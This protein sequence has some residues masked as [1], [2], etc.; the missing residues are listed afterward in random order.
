LRAHG[1]PLTRSGGITLALPVRERGRGLRIRRG[2][3]D[4]SLGSSSQVR[5]W[6]LAR[7]AR[8]TRRQFRVDRPRRWVHLD[9]C[10]QRSVPSAGLP[11]SPATPRAR[12]TL[13]RACRFGSISPF[14]EPVGLPAW[15]RDSP[16]ARLD[17]L[18]RRLDSLGAAPSLSVPS[19]LLTRYPNRDSAVVGL[20]GRHGAHSSG[21]ERSPYKR[22][23]VGSNPTAPT[24][25]NS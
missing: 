12:R 6:V 17:R 4:R 22:K 10:V 16:G 3:F 19:G 2:A 24:R 25:Q 15:P 5:D 8:L 11:V 14:S 20:L 23:V 18:F 1:F 13:S 21:E 9:L 7:T